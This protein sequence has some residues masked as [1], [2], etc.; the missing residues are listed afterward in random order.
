VEKSTLPV[1]A[2]EGETSSGRRSFAVLSNPEFLV[3]AAPR[4]WSRTVD[5]VGRASSDDA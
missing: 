3:E 1:G 4:R 2:A 5:L